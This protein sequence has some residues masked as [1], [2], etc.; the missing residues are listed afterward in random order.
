MKANNVKDP[1]LLF[2]GLCLFLV[3]VLYA[4]ER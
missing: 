2:I 4:L 1:L 3:I